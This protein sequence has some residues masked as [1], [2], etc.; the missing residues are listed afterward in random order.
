MRRHTSRIDRRPDWLRLPVMVVFYEEVV[1]A[2]I[3]DYLSR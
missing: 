2:Q 3:V 1:R